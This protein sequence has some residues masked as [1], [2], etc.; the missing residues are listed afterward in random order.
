MSILR[1]CAAAFSTF[2]LFGT[3][4]PLLRNG[5]GRSQSLHSLHS[6]QENR[7]GTNQEIMGNKWLDRK[8]QLMDKLMF[9]VLRK[10]VY[11]KKRIVITTTQSFYLTLNLIPWKTRCKSTTYF[12]YYQIICKKNMFYSIFLYILLCWHSKIGVQI[13]IAPH[14]TFLL[15][16]PFGYHFVKRSLSR[17]CRN[18]IETLSKPKHTT[19][20]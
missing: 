4:N 8:K 18:L 3:K 10:S 13:P 17:F 9:I 16:A 14:Y 5:L 6:G 1:P 2:S 19:E 15:Y 12:W 7:Y 20:Q 11:K